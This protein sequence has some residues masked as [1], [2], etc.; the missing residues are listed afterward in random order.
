MTTTANDSIGQTLG[1]TIVW[2]GLGLSVLASGCS[3]ISGL[4]SVAPG[5][6]SWLGFRDRSSPGSPSPENDHYA[7]RM[8]DSGVPGTAVAQND[9][10]RAEVGDDRDV[11]LAREHSPVASDEPEPE[12]DDAIA[13]K[14]RRGGKSSV[15]VTLSRPEPLPG[16]MLASNDAA[17]VASSTA[18]SGRKSGGAAEEQAEGGTQIAR[19]DEQSARTEPVPA[20]APPADSAVP[21]RHAEAEQSTRSA[22][23][24]EVLGEIEAHLASLETYQV[25]FRRAERIGGQMQPD[26]EIIL[27]V[28]RKPKAV[29]LE[30]TSGPS[31]GREV[32]YASTIDPRK[33]FVHMGNS[34]IPLPPMKIAVDSPLVMKNSRHAITEAGF[35]TIVA[36]LRRADGGNDKNQID[37][38]KLDYM[39]VAQ[40]PDSDRHGHHFVRHA[41]N[42]ETWNVYFDTDSMMPILVTA[43]DSTGA[44]IERYE[45]RDVRENPTELATASAFEP[46]KRWGESQGILS[47]FARAAAGTNSPGEG[48]STTR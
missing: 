47:R 16:M 9:A 27:S 13:A 41:Q 43:A 33:L 21:T 45:Y 7:Q 46:D 4:R 32:I 5:M 37:G 36:N 25:K 18:A 11:P 34:A 42:G 44:L 10:K 30:W 20:E 17:I 6:P 1:R 12:P 19:T 48:Q 23:A 39:G 28:Q 15:Q 14:P 38:G 3:G 29:R 35:D 2:C 8:R 22:R 24:Q 26:E 31:K 40:A